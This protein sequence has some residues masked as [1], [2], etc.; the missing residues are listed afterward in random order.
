MVQET[1]YHLK[2]LIIVNSI[3]DEIKELKMS[4]IEERNGPLYRIYTNIA[5]IGLET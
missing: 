4:I 2:I 3:S 1:I 5:G